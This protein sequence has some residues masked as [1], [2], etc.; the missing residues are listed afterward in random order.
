MLLNIAATSLASHAA[1]PV[2]VTF[3]LCNEVLILITSVTCNRILPASKP[4]PNDI[5]RT[6]VSKLITSS[7]RK[8]IFSRASTPLGIYDTSLK[9]FAIA[10]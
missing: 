4:N 8:V 6:R 5:C 3:Q 2:G 9:L 7:V 10:S 1:S